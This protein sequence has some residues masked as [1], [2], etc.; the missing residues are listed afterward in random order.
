MHGPRVVTSSRSAV[1]SGD[2]HP[3]SLDLKTTRSGDYLK[4]IGAYRQGMASQWEYRLEEMSPDA[5]TVVQHL[6]DESA[7]GW[8]LVTVIAADGASSKNRLVLLDV[9]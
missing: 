6:N 8:D 7:E 9:R 1:L 4:R 3:T 2:T 5:G